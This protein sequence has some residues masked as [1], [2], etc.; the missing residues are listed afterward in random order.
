MSIPRQRLAALLLA[1]TMLVVGLAALPNLC[2]E[3]DDDC[4]SNPQHHTD[5]SCSCSCH[6]A[7]EL[8]LVPADQQPTASFDLA[9]VLHGAKTSVF[10]AQPT[11]PPR[12]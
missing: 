7:V 12:S 6:I 1:T 8:P 10:L 2:H 9:L 3:A 5:L 11:P 4:R